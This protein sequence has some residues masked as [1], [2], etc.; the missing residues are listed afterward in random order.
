M[1]AQTSRTCFSPPGTWIAGSAALALLWCSL[2]LS[3]VASVQAQTEADPPA[4]PR[5]VPVQPDGVKDKPAIARPVKA[6]PVPIPPP[7]TGRVVAKPVDPKVIDESATGNTPKVNE[8]REQA[9]ED[10]IAYADLLFS[11]QKWGLAA[12]QY[13]VFLKEHPTSPNV[14]SAW[15]RLGECYLAA[16]Q[17]TDAM[18]SFSYLV[19]RFK[20]GDFVGAAAYR[21]A[22]TKFTAGDHKTAL[23]YFDIAANE[24]PAAE[25]R[26]QAS[27]YGA[28][29]LELLKRNEEAIAAY[30]EVLA[31]KPAADSATPDSEAAPNAEPG[32]SPEEAINPFAE[33]ASLSIA[34]LLNQDK[35]TQAAYEQY[36]ALSKTAKIPAVKQESLARAGLLAAQL[37]KPEESNRLLDAV[38]NVKDG[39]EEAAAEWKGTAQVA[40]IFNLYA[41]EQYDR[42]V[43][44]YNRGITATPDDIRPKMLVMVANSMRQVGELKSAANVYRIIEQNYREDA[45]A[46]EAIFRKLQCLDQIEDLDLVNEIDRFVSSQK[47]Y[48]AD[49]PFID[50]ALLMKGEWHFQRNDWKAAAS[51]YA[52]VRPKSIPEKYHPARLYKLGWA[53]TESGEVASGITHLTSFIKNFP[54]DPFV[55]SALTK[56]AVSQLALDNHQDALVD[57]KLIAEEYPE[58]DQSEFV[59]EQIAFIHNVQREVPE[60]VAAYQRLLDKFPETVGAA[61]AWY[62]IGAG[63][64]DQKQYAEAIEPLLTARKLDKEAF[65]TRATEVLILCYFRQ[66]DIEGLSREANLA[67]NAKPPISVPIPVLNY[68][69]EVHFQQ[70]DYKSS[71]NFFSAASTPSRPG[72]TPSAVWDYLGRARHQ[73]GLF[74]GAVIAFDNYLGIV[75]S[76][77]DRAEGYLNKSR[78]LLSAKKYQAADQAAQETLKLV[79]QGKLNARGRLMRGDI[80]LARGDSA[81]AAREYFITSQ[82]FVGD[83]EI[84]PQAMAK[85]AKAYRTGGDAAKADEIEAQLKQSY[86]DYSLPV[87]G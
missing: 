87:E 8:A 20:K 67:L 35:D 62:Y 39:S 33:R 37:G 27:Y 14:P 29:S 30:R 15:F 7:P 21:I 63:H 53:E 46:A 2:V 77:R 74:G 58:S 45:I 80:A 59:L 11:R 3:P 69:G 42:V 51:A 24:A 48:D 5:A 6:V 50:L 75:Q 47:K 56:R 84:T 25:L 65:T 23:Q 10:L 71:E 40:L 9:R 64:Y 66:K 32:E 60:M 72:E 28:R 38:L 41:A 13:Q 1:A 61:E 82:I 16:D 22:T 76:P 4:A 49:S 57:F 19:N 83:P 73:I 18:T 70:G 31:T 78:S 55:A 17:K 34:R 54:D 52:T 86:P 44:V 12:A 36:L 68:L 26:L 43:G 79:H 85:A 81:T